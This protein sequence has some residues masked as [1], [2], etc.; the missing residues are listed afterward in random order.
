MDGH[1]VC[2]FAYG[3]TGTGKTFTMYGT[4]EEPRMIP[5]ALEE[6]FRQASLDN[7]SLMRINIFRCGDAME[8]KSEVSKLWMIDLGGSKQ[9]L[10]TGAK[11]LTLDEGRA[12]NL[13]LSALGDDALKR[14]RCHVPYRL[15]SCS[16]DDFLFM[17]SSLPLE[18]RCSVPRLVWSD[19]L[20]CQVQEWKGQ[21]QAMVRRGLLLE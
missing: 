15:I 4:N 9:L 20:E 7:A 8:A 17:L 11:G 6:L 13:S 3:Q 1:N 19:P 12:I 21:L 18:E 16:Q 10:K 2:A 14:K 5:R